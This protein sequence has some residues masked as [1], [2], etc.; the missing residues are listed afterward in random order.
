MEFINFLLE[1]KRNGYASAGERDETKL[2]DGG[3]RLIY[4]SGEFLYKDIYYG[5]D[6]FIGEELVFKNGVAIWGMNYYG[7]VLD[8]SV[9][10]GEVYHFLQQAMRQVGAKRPFRGPDNLRDGDWEYRDASQGDL[11]CFN[12]EENIFFQGRLVYRL[13]Y[14]GGRL[15]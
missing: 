14:H 4:R 13:T 3:K 9:R 10:A 11:D 2:E 5:N 1:S 15:G 6:P 7:L 12:G 8:P